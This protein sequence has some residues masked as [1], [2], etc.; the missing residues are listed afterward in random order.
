MNRKGIGI[1][2]CKFQHATATRCYHVLMTHVDLLALA[3]R[4]L[5][6]RSFTSLKNCDCRLKAS[7][8]HHPIRALS[9]SR[10]HSELNHLTSSLCPLGI[11]VQMSEHMLR[12]DLF[13]ILSPNLPVLPAS[14][15]ES[16]RISYFSKCRPEGLPTPWLGFLL[17]VGFVRFGIKSRKV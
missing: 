13:P 16:M 5:F 6:M 1:F 15:K 14:G 11:S 12:Y 17:V 2:L 10:P 3:T 7:L 9:Q 4:H 8:L